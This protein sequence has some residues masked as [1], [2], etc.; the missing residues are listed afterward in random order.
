[1][2]PQR[3]IIIAIPVLSQDI[4]SNHIK[5]Q[6]E[7][8]EEISKSTQSI[9]HDK[10]GQQ[11]YYSNLT[12]SAMLDDNFGISPSLNK[13]SYSLARLNIKKLFQ[14]NYFQLATTLFHF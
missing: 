9:P 5:V 7:R 3:V 2:Q 10:D 4:Q 6:K 13:L 8:I 14:Y 12:R 1:M 11:L